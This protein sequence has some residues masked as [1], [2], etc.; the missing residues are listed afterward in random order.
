MKQRRYRLVIFDVTGT[1]TAVALFEK[2]YEKFGRKEETLRLYNLFKKREI[3]ERELIERSAILYAGIPKSAFYELAEEVPL[4]KGA[5]EVL[6]T[7][8]RAGIIN[9][10]IS[11][12]YSILL[13]ILARRF[14]IK[15]TYGCEPIFDKNDLFTGK[16][17]LVVTAEKKREL[18]LEIVRKEGLQLTEVVVVGNGLNDIKMFEIAGLSIAFNAD[19]PVK[20]QADVTIDECDLKSILPYILNFKNHNSYDI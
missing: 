14:R 16:L 5:E 18:M 7:L 10:L 2:L 12:D 13:E 6:A 11:A 4:I 19:H 20:E 17:G 15:Y 8:S 1:I 3:S 9:A